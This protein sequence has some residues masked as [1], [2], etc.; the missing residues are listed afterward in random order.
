MVT[1]GYQMHRLLQPIML[2]LEKGCRLD[3]LHVGV[4]L[5]SLLL[6]GGQL[7]SLAMTKVLWWW[8]LWHLLIHELL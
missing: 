2:A 3:L 5:C 1:L 8:S 4:L 6:L 7:R